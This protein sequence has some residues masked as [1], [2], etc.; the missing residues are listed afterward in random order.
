M[1]AWYLLK[2]VPTV[3][4]KVDHMPPWVSS[5]MRSGQKKK[6]YKCVLATI[7]CHWQDITR[8]KWALNLQDLP[9]CN[10]RWKEMESRDSGSFTV[11]KI[12]RP[13]IMRGMTSKKLWAMKTHR[14]YAVEHWLSPAANMR[15]VVLHSHPR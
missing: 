10:Q 8:T 15:S 7:S 6:K 5:S 2:A 13:N 12:S 9:I 14:V 3:T 1:M 4:W 11:I